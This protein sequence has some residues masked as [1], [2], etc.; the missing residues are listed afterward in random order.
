MA[1]TW[2]EV[3][4]ASDAERAEVELIRFAMRDATDSVYKVVFVP[5]KVFFFINK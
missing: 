3:T 2:D 1:S 4:A 5:V